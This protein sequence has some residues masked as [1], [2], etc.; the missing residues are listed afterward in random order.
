[1]YLYRDNIYIYITRENRAIE[2]LMSVYMAAS[3]SQKAKVLSPTS[4]A[5]HA[6][7]KIGLGFQKIA[8]FCWVSLAFPKQPNSGFCRVSNGVGNPKMGFG[9]PL[10]FP[11]QPESGLC[12]VSGGRPRS[13]NGVGTLT[14]AS[15]FPSPWLSLQGSQKAGSPT[16][17]AGKPRPS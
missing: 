1:M 15:A 5:V 13:E 16:E 9:V 17:D 12:R 14:W 2:G 11:L 10:N 6:V 8:G 4:G 7:G 3:M